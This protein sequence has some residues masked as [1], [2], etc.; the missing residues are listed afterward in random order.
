MG[1][2]ILV[3]AGSQLKFIAPNTIY[4]QKN[5]FHPNS[6]LHLEDIINIEAHSPLSVPDE[7]SISNIGHSLNYRRRLL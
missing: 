6:L 1:S 7:T 3:H 4:L 2:A 5:Q